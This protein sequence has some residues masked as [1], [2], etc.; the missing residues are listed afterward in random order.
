MVCTTSPRD[1]FIYSCPGPRL[2]KLIPYFQ[3]S[4]LK[5]SFSHSNKIIPPVPINLHFILFFSFSTLYS[6]ISAPTH[7]LYFPSL[8]S[9][10]PI[11]L[12]SMLY[13]PYPYYLF[14]IPHSLV[15]YS[16]VS[17]PHSLVPYSPVSI[18]HSH[19][20]SSPVSIPHAHSLVPYS[21]VSIL[22]L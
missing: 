20:H 9:S 12:F 3:T 21:P 18:P 14:S 11:P 15:P 8:P 10:F 4:Y 2:Q 5:H 19:S 17:I 16:P 7:T 1:D 6:P 13:S 22:I